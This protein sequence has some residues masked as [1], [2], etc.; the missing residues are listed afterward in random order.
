M[1]FLNEPVAKA[2]IWWPLQL[3][4]PHSLDLAFNDCKNESILTRLAKRTNLV[5]HYFGYGKMHSIAKETAKEL[6]LPFRVTVSFAP[7]RF[8]SSSYHQFL[9]LEQS[10]EVY[11][12][13]FKDRNNCKLTLYQIAGQDFLFDLMGMLDLLWPFVQSLTYPGWK[14]D[15]SSFDSIE[16]IQH[17]NTD[18]A[19][20]KTHLPICS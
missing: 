19:S 18:E 5:H 1:E 13:T 3:D 16:A 6:Q 14:L 15:H 12:E 11:I 2:N 4:P 8:L 17:R 10:L 7:Q 9:K 20:K